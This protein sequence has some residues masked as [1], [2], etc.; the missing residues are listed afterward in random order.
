MSYEKRIDLYG[1]GIGAVEYIQHMG[2]DLT[3]VNSAR[4]SYGNGKQKLDAG[5]QNLIKYLLDNRHTSPFEHCTVTF[6]FT[7]PMY[8]S[9]QHMRHRTWSYN[10]IS[11]RY[12]DVDLKFYE[13]NSYRSQHKT[14]RQASNNDAIN[15]TLG[16]LPTRVMAGARFSKAPLPANKAVIKHH[17]DALR[18]YNGLIEFG[19][20]R[21]Q[22]RGVLPQNLYTQYF[23]TANLSNIFKFISLRLPTDAQWEI[24]AVARA[25]LEIT[26]NCF[27]VATEAWMSTNK[28]QKPRKTDDWFIEDWS[29]V[30]EPPKKEEQPKPKK[31]KGFFSR[32]K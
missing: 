6:R 27:P 16:N 25:V 14:D 29:E 19:V 15:P 9:K 24:Q 7:V 8:I 28:V 18:L 22:A 4:V 11:R 26:S 30:V 32:G 20:C 10:E 13:P 5:D 17:K 21:E 23:G 12:T 1:D 2:S 31:K 3:I